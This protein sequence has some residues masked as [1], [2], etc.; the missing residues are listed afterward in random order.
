M[1]SFFNR[2]LE[3]S[4]FY[5]QKNMEKPTLYIIPS[6]NPSFMNVLDDPYF[7]QLVDERGI[8]EYTIIHYS[9]ILND[10]CKLLNKTPTLLIEEAVLEEE[11]GIRLPQ[12]KIKQHLT[13]YRKHLEDKGYSPKTIKGSMVVVRTFYNEYDI[14]L[15]KTRYKHQTKDPFQTSKDLPNKEQIRQALKH[16]DFKYRAIILLMI[17]SGMGSAE[18]R[19]IKYKDFFNA[20]DA[21]YSQDNIY[22]S[23]KNAA[24]FRDEIPTWKLKRI[25]TGNQYFTFSSPESSEAILDYLHKKHSLQGT[26]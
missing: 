6:P 25:K 2:S 5:L 26:E 16:C 13:Q 24:A 9:I 1:Y 20:L 4:R 22:Q 11:Q 7:Q 19:H 8:K 23:I 15:P 10:Y 21:E 17:S 3:F 18:I 14:E 12:R